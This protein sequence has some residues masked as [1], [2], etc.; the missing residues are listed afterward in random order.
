MADDGPTRAQ[1]SLPHMIP[2]WLETV[3]SIFETLDFCRCRLYSACWRRCSTAEQDP[4]YKAH[5]RL[6]R[7]G[8][9][10]SQDRVDAEV[11]D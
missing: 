7:L 2:V 10:V 9:S 1:Q 4:V 8:A 6:E 3:L 11:F 5:H